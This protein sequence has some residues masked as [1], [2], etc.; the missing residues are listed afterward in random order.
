V[1]PLN[2][3]QLRP[4]STTVA[5][6]ALLACPV[7]ALAQDQRPDAAF[8]FKPEDPRAGQEVRFLS[9]SCDPDGRLVRQTWDLDGDGVYDD[10]E[11]PVATR[12]FPDSGAREVG[13]EVTAEGG[14]T[15]RHRRTVFVNTVY[16]L[17]RPDRD[18]LMSPYPVVRMAGALTRDGARVRV[19]SVSRAPVCAL[20]R[21]SCRGRG[22]PARRRASAYTDRGRLRFR[23]FERRLREG[24]VVT[25]RVSKNDLIGKFTQ[26]R[27]REGKAPR[28]RDR[29]LR[30]GERSGSPCPRD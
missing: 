28:R 17:P 14:T 6:L 25:V 22:C 11:G 29:C 16:A 26:F 2:W 10:A 18:R 9:S 1:V 20:V 19:L 27:I 3:T 5:L 23:R 30:P 4:R 13:L 12:T 21:V 15:D 7:A 24:A 8:S